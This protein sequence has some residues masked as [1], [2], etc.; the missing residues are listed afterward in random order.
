VRNVQAA[1]VVP[2]TGHNRCSLVAVATK[3]GDM[4]I[5]THVAEL[6][7]ELVGANLDLETAF[8]VCACSTRNERLRILL[9]AR[10]R[11]SG[12]AARVLSAVLAAPDCRREDH[13]TCARSTPNWI[14][15]HDALEAD[16]DGV[17]RDEC[18]RIEEETLLRYRDVLQSDLPRDIQQM[19][20]KYFAA[21]LEH[22]GTLRALDLA[23]PG[24]TRRRPPIRF[25]HVPADFVNSRPGHA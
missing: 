11:I 15:L 7:D 16:D 2:R 9:L 18:C 1:I 24:D 8:I 23:Q 17:V 10:A 4:I 21:L 22:Y 25:G 19:V 14:V 3:E 5:R 20:Q 13:V 6:L 12:E